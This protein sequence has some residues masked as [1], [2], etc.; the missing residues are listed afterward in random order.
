MDTIWERDSR[1]IY[2]IVDSY[3]CCTVLDELAQEDNWL[4]VFKHV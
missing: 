4:S 3:A 1:K 2:Y